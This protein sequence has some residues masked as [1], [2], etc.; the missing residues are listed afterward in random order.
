MRRATWILIALV[1]VA[2]GV[3]WHLRSGSQ[4]PGTTASGHDRTMAE[5]G[6][7]GSAAA[8]VVRGEAR[9]SSTATL[10]ALEAQAEIF[11][12]FDAWSAAFLAERDGERRLAAEV[13][14]VRLAAERRVV[15]HELIAE[16]PQRAIEHAVPWAVRHALPDEV[17]AL[18]EERVDGMGSLHALAAIAPETGSPDFRAARR[19]VLIDGRTYDAFTYGKRLESGSRAR[20][21]VHGIAI[22]GRLALLDSAVRRLDPGEP[23]PAGRRVET[24]CAVSGQATDPATATAADTG[25]RVIYLCAAG[26]ISVLAAQLEDAEAPA[27]AGEPVP[28]AAGVSDAQVL[29]LDTRRVLMIRVRFADQAGHE[30]E[31]AA[32]AAEVFSVAD[33]FYRENSFGRLRIEGTVSPVYTLPQTAA[34]YAANDTSG[35]ALNVLQ[36]ARA[37]AADPGSVPASAGLPAFSYLDYDLEAVRY[38]GGPGTFSGQGYV[39]MRGC[40]IKSPEPGVLIHELGHNLGLWH[41]NAWKPADPLAPLGAGVNDEYGDTLDTMGPPRGGAWHFNAWEKKRLGWLPVDEVAVLTS[42]ATLALAPL[43]VPGAAPGDDVVRAVRVRRDDDR[44]I[45]LELRGH[46]GWAEARPGVTQGVGVRWDPWLRSNGGTQLID[47]TPGSPDRFDD[48]TLAVGRTF[49]DAA[50]GIHVTPLGPSAADASALDVAIFVGDSAGNRPPVVAVAASASDAGVGQPVR[51]TASASDADG[52]ALSYAWTFDGSGAVVSGAEVV[53]AWPAGGDQRAR[54]TVSDRRGGTA[55]ASVLVRVGAVSGSRI[56]GR[57]IDLGGRQVSDAFVHNATEPGA[58]GYRAARSDSDGT[59]ALLGVPA[60]R[61]GVEAGAP[62]WIFAMEGFS[63]PVSV[64]ADAGGVTILGFWRGFSISG[65][66]RRADGSALPGALVRVG[67]RVEPTDQYGEFTLPGLSPGRHTLTVEAGDAV[68][69]PRLI[70][71]GQSDVDDVFLRERTFT[72]AGMLVGSGDVAG[73]TVTNGWQSTVVAGTGTPGAGRFELGGVPGG[74]WVLRALSDDEA[75]D[76]QAVTPPMQVSDDVA[77]V[78]LATDGPARY[79]IAGVVRDRGF[80][81]AGATVA[82]GTRTT[83]TDSRGGYWLA[84]FEPGVHEVTVSAP[85]RSFAPATRTVGIA[86]THV[87]GVDF[88]TDRVN[89]V[90]VL[91]LAPRVLGAVNQPFVTVGVE[92]SDDED[93]ALIRYWWSVDEGAAGGVIFATNGAHAARETV[94]RFTQPGE[95]RLRVTAVDRHGAETTGTLALTV[96]GGVAAPVII[97]PAR[98]DPPVVGS[99]LETRL[100]IRAASDAGEDQL[101]Y[102]WSLLGPDGTLDLSRVAGPVAFSAN[103]S[104]EA[105]ETRVTFRNPGDYLFHVTVEDAYGQTA[106]SAVAVHVE[107]TYDSWLSSYFDYATTADPG[108]RAGVWGELADPDGDGAVNLLEYAFGGDPTTAS[109]DNRPRTHFLTEEG[110]E[111]LAVTFRPNPKAVDLVFEPQVSGDLENWQGGLVFLPGSDE[112]ALTYRDSE[113]AAA[114]Q[115]RFIRVHVTRLGPGVP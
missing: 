112:R 31:T 76:L 43:D 7:P 61:W 51:F 101:T 77:G 83:I 11:G 32:S 98:A 4:A 107:V 58:D 16:D 46:P 91:S 87:S 109:P 35:Y 105:R 66:V 15:L 56:T 10:R 2:G 92:A 93:E 1:A 64:P 85:G 3:L 55:T 102:T 28:A 103:M 14:G 41:A 88:T 63:R 38:T 25:D 111:Y 68:F 82:S 8:H 47:T 84:G 13:Q 72:V 48:A 69:E 37:V 60:G 21:A 45:W 57:L 34:W 95:Y 42:S 22:D 81:L 5:A 67:D 30:P 44:D 12:R 97:E 90:P 104:A 62:G 80:G 114:H 54:V 49:S 71:V 36:A 115:R 50:A 39:A 96:R 70:E 89:Q 79:G 40:W 19:E 29:A 73:V 26:H 74:S 18:L 94:V 78:T 108:L 17:Q 75:F 23:V 9:R 52:D 53:H 99:S 65:S 6:V 59:F 106:E 24:V 113:P 20:L 110:V 100:T 86:G 33:A 27:Q